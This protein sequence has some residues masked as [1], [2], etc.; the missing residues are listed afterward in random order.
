MPRSQDLPFTCRAAYEK[1]LASGL[2]SKTRKTVYD[3][4]AKEGPLTQRE[5]DSQLG[6]D[7][8]KRVSELCK[9][10]VVQSVGLGV[11][12][13]SGMESQLWDITE[14][15]PPEKISKEVQNFTGQTKAILEIKRAI[16]EKKR[17]VE[18]NELLYKLENT[19][20]VDSADEFF[21]LLNQI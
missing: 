11:C 6:F 3:F 2:L 20:N 15:F 12:K 19:Y 17:S 8:H 4:I 14:H 10:K 16:P 21:D 18:L 9:Q 13:I 1:N 5:L 7:A